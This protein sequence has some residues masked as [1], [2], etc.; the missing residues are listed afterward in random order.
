VKITKLFVR[1]LHIVDTED[2]RAMGYLYQAMY[3]AIDE[4][5]KRFKRN[6]LKMEPYLKILDNHWDAQLRKNLHGGGYWLNP[7]SRFNPE[8][9][10]LFGFY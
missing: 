8:H 4:N 1:V 7:Y 9:I 10:R 5:E 3:K 6:R 2:K